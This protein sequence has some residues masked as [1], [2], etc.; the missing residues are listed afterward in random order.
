[1]LHP[2]GLTFFSEINNETQPI[3]AK[4]VAVKVA[5]ESEITTFASVTIDTTVNRG[6][7]RVDSISSFYNL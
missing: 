3:D 2:A 5:A 4:S 7:L 1:M 6:N